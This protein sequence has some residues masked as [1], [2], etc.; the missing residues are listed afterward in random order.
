MVSE[1]EP[2]AKSSAP[3]TVPP[4]NWTVSFPEPNRMSP[5]STGVMVVVVVLVVPSLLVVVV[6]VVVGAV[7]VRL[8]P[9][10]LLCRSNAMALPCTMSVDAAGFADAEMVLLLTTVD[11]LPELSTTAVAE[12][13]S[14]VKAA[15]MLPVLAR[16]LTTAP[17]S[18]CT[19][20]DWEAMAEVTPAVMAPSLRSAETVAPL[21]RWRATA[22]CWK[23]PAFTVPMLRKPLSMWTVPSP[24]PICRPAAAMLSNT[25]LPETVPATIRP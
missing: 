11:S 20:V 16:L 7:W 19:A 6:V 12:P 9:E 5:L 17:A 23:A 8:I 25:P 24:V 3:V 21:A 15:V 22:F 1:P 14:P 13:R 4:W 18:I 2:A 10:V